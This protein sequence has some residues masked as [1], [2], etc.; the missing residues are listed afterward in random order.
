M[1]ERSIDVVIANEGSIK[2]EY[3]EKYETKEQKD[4]VILDEEWYQMSQNILEDD[5]NQIKGKMQLV[6]ELLRRYEEAPEEERI[7]CICTPK[8][9]N[10]I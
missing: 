7:S 1:G 4:Q 5:Y 3:L 2:K 8:S 10:A 9:A 6:E